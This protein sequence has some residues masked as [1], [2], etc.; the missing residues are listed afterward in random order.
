MVLTQDVEFDTE[1]KSAIIDLLGNFTTETTPPGAAKISNFGDYLPAGSTVFITFLPGSDFEDTIVTAKRLR[2]EGYVPV[3]HIAARRIPSAGFLDENL[4]RLT[5]EAGVSEVLV[6]GGSV[7]EPVGAFTSSMEV[8]ETGLLDK[9]GILRIGVAGHPEGSPDICDEDIAK[10]L[11]WKNAFAE[12]T[13]AEVYIVTQFCFE[14]RP[15]IAW[16]KR[17]RAGG[18]QLPIRVGVPGL[19]SVK[20]LLNYARLCGIGPS[21]NFIAKQARNVTKLVTLSAPDK[22]LT[23]LAAYRAGDP[24]CGITGCHIY[25]L[26]GLQKTARWAR[27]VLQGQ[28]SLDRKNAGFKVDVQVD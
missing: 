10:A 3:P 20:S 5:A 16:D 26:G 11:A 6:I 25:P 12:R 17:I 15:V 18:N 14:A 23:E 4:R 8:L 7:P 22:L 1:L 2:R 19:A 13:L 27:A 24:A 21:M 28:F 9:H